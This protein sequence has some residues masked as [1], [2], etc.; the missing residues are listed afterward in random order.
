[1]GFESKLPIE[2]AVVHRRFED[3]LDQ[4]GRMS[5]LFEAL[6]TEIDDPS[7]A[8]LFTRLEDPAVVEAAEA[9][10]RTAPGWASICE[11]IVCSLESTTHWGNKSLRIELLPELRQLWPDAR[12][13]VLTRDP[14][15]VMA[16]QQKK[17]DHSIEYSAV[18][19]NTHAR[20]IRERLGLGQREHDETTMVVDIV[21][22][23]RDPRPALTWAF[24]GVGLGLAPVESLIERFPGDP[25]RLDAWRGSL[26]D[27]RQ[28]RIEEY[29]FTEMRHLGY[30][31]ELAVDQREIGR[32]RRA[33]AIAREHGSAALQ[34]PSA[35]RR[36]RVGHRVKVALGIGR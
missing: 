4:P 1:M 30:V 28:R 2:G 33:L 26:D 22:M 20:W 5:Q 21:D 23:A 25:D 6:H 35:L 32:V 13:L 7:N 8:E 36:K 12:F 15:G 27:D 31:P 17:F 10:N 9:A 18:Y 16:S 14:R 34:D 11:A 29:C 19:W 3:S 24:D